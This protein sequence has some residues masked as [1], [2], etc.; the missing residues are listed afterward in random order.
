[1]NANVV[2][3]CETTDDGFVRQITDISLPPDARS[4]T[5]ALGTGEFEGFRLHVTDFDTAMFVLKGG[6][7][8]YFLETGELQD[9][10]WIEDVS[11]VYRNVRYPAIAREKSVSGTVVLDLYIDQTGCIETVMASTDIGSGLEESSIDAVQKCK[12]QWTTA[13]WGGIKMPT[14]IRLPISFRFQ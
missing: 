6:Q 7:R 12:C 9:D 4:D 2:V 3:E 14:I 11:C 10:V 8:Y 1:M 5:F 13:T